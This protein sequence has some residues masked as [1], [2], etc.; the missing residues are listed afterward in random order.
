MCRFSTNP[1]RAFDPCHLPAFLGKGNIEVASD[2]RRGCHTS[3]FD[4]NYFLVICRRKADHVLGT[5]NGSTRSVF[6]QA[7]SVHSA[8]ICSNAN[9]CS[10]FAPVPPNGQAARGNFALCGSRDPCIPSS[11]ATAEELD[12]D[13]L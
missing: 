8:L 12:R 2:R 13:D 10:Q 1:E 7:K 5:N 3:N 11:A 9:L 4:S 6:T